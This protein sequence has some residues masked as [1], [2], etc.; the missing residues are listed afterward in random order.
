M[1]NYKEQV[2]Q[3]LLEELSETL[4]VMQPLVTRKLEG[5]L[6][7][8]YQ[9]LQRMV[10]VWSCI[11]LPDRGEYKTSHLCLRPQLLDFQRI[12]GAPSSSPRKLSAAPLE[13]GARPGAHRNLSFRADPPLS[14]FQAS[15]AGSSPVSG[16]WRI[17]PNAG[18][19]VAVVGPA[20]GSGRPLG[21]RR[22]AR[23]VRTEAQ[24]SRLVSV[25]RPHDGGS[26]AGR[27]LL[28]SCPLDH[29]ENREGVAEASVPLA[30]AFGSVVPTA[31]G[32][33]DGDGRDGGRALSVLVLDPGSYRSRRINA[34]ISR[35]QERVQQ[36][37][38]Q[39]VQ[40]ALFDRCELHIG[41][42]GVA[43]VRLGRGAV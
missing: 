21:G 6:A 20:S 40:Q 42:W 38:R 19:A 24:L 4:S 23:R 2:L 41:R 35:F 22:Q 25:G 17:S 14:A 32:E 5:G 34:L 15:V 28:D 27:P 16:K 29:R 12:Q 8:E 37:Q 36:A 11:A 26:R 18:G 43:L 3:T 39:Q 10:T 9:L 1:I 7:D 30:D 13:K 31:G 33:D